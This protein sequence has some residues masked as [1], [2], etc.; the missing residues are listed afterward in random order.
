MTVDF[1]SEATRA[2][3]ELLVQM[4]AWGDCDMSRLLNSLSAVVKCY[5]RGPRLVVPMLSDRR[6]TV[7]QLI[8]YCEHFFGAIQVYGLGTRC[9]PLF[10][11]SG[12]LGVKGDSIV[13]EGDNRF[14]TLCI[15][16]VAA[17]RQRLS[18]EKLWERRYDLGPEWGQVLDDS[19]FHRNASSDFDIWPVYT[20]RSRDERLFSMTIAYVRWRY[21]LSTASQ[22]LQL[23]IISIREFSREEFKEH[24]FL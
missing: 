19:P 12:G 10:Q 3:N 6:I 16:I 21:S 2:Q 7:G 1:V 13:V 23:E 11:P 20:N 14:C 4:P 22:A 24:V 15:P 9:R 5:D 18:P 17:M 8:A